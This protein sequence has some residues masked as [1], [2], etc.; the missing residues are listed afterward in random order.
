MLYGRGSKLIHSMLYESIARRLGIKV[1]LSSM[2]NNV[3][4]F[5][6]SSW[7]KSDK[8]KNKLYFIDVHNNGNVIQTPARLHSEQISAENKS[9]FDVS[10]NP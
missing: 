8:R 3:N 7:P 4:V 9:V 6:T 5:W 1:Q 2:Y 10:N